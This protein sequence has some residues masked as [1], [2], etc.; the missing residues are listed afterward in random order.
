MANNNYNNPN[1]SSNKVKKDSISSF[2]GYFASPNLDNFQRMLEYLEK[3]GQTL[4]VRK[5]IVKIKPAN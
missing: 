5:K 4:H 1:N 3:S 2:G